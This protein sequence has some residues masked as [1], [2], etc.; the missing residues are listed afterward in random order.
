MQGCLLHHL[1]FTFSTKH[2]LELNVRGPRYRVLRDEMHQILNLAYDSVTK[3]L[4]WSQRKYG[5]IGV[6]ETEGNKFSF[7][8]LAKYEGVDPHGL[9]V[10][11]TKRY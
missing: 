2:L 10:H 7:A 1:V 11:I 4:Y 6:I 8:I 3:I 5:K 9:A